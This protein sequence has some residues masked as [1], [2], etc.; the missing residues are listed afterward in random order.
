[1][2]FENEIKIQSLR[3]SEASSLPLAVLG[4]PGLVGLTAS[5]HGLDLRVLPRRSSSLL[6]AGGSLCIVLS[7]GLGTLLGRLSGGA[8]GRS[9][10]TASRLGVGCRRRGGNRLRRGRSGLLSIGTIASVCCLKML[11]YGAIITAMIGITRYE[12]VQRG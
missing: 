10:H 8:A 4:H 12:C 9:D 1:M 5:D 7:R 3:S 2:L 11:G 6:R